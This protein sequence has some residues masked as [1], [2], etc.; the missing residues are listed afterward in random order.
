MATDTSLETGT[1]LMGVCRLSSVAWVEMSPPPLLPPPLLPQRPFENVG[2]EGFAPYRG[3]VPPH[4][5]NPRVRA[6]S[7]PR[8]RS[9]TEAFGDWSRDNPG[10]KIWKNTISNF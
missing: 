6:L 3:R 4:L 1:C 8:H 5:P 2:G 7:V 10:V 9:E